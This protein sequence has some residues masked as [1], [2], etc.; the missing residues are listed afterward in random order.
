MSCL[1]VM[2]EEILA[3]PEVL[4]LGWFRDEN[5]FSESATSER[6]ILRHMQP[7]RKTILKLISGDVAGDTND[8]RVEGIMQR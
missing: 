8:L 5:L 6:E 1:Y 4:S 2:T 7:I 3:E